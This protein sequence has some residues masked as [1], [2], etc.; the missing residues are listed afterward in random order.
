MQGYYWEKF[1]IDHLWKLKGYKLKME[2]SVIDFEP[3]LLLLFLIL[4]FCKSF[5]QQGGGRKGTQRVLWR[6]YKLIYPSL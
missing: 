6:I 1:Y 3:F 5:L 4:D 2:F